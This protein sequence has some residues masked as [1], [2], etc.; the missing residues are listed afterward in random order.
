MTA[1]TA[2]TS[3]VSSSGTKI[4]S[5]T[6]ATGDGTSVS[7]LSVETSSKGSSTSILSPTFFNQRVTVP[8]VT[9]SP[10]AGST[11]DSL[12]VRSQIVLSLVFYGARLD[13]VQRLT[14]E[15][16]HGLADRLVLRRVTVNKRRDIL[17]VGLPVHNE[18]RF[19]DKFADTCTDHVDPDDRSI[20]DP[21]GLDRSSSAKNRALRIARKIVLVGANVLAAVLLRRLRFGET[22]GGNLGITVGDLWH[23]HVLD[24]DRVEPGDLFGNE[25]ALLVS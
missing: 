17:G 21:H 2:P 8:S 7:T 24:N 10:S 11:T 12:I 22:D 14:G 1:R 16:Q 19:T 4:S 9:L 25:H 15:L 18:L 13:S 23:V 3:A 5:R 20:V 6:P